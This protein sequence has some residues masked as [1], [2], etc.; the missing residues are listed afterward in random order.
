LL[1]Y[2]SK[3][4]IQD[5]D[6]SVEGRMVYHFINLVF[7]GISIEGI[8]LRR[9]IEVLEKRGLMSQGTW[10]GGAAAGAINPAPLFGLNFNSAGLGQIARSSLLK[11][12]II[13]FFCCRNINPSLSSS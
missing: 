2:Y 12:M 10:A 1:L 3:K 13:G 8:A 7:L 4:N 11:H 9:P 6:T 5:K